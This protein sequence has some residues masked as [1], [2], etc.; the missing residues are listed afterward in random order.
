MKVQ[1]IYSSTFV[2]FLRDRPSS[3]TLSCDIL[4]SLLRPAKRDRGSEKKKEGDNDDEMR[5]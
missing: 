5:Y 1:Y 2:E 3:S 4:R